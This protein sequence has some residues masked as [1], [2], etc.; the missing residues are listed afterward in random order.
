MGFK[1]LKRNIIVTRQ[2]DCRSTKGM[3]AIICWIEL[4][5][6]QE[7]GEGGTDHRSR[8]RKGSRRGGK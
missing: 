8:N 6:R 7:L 2:R 1:I 3:K 5:R 4:K